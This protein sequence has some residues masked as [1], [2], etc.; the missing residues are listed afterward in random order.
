VGD[1]VRDY[2]EIAES[3]EKALEGVALPPAFAG[4]IGCMK[5][6]PELVAKIACW[7]DTLWLII[8]R[9]LNNGGS[10]TDE[11]YFLHACALLESEEA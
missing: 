10:A 6:H 7:D 8:E 3:F 9:F 5:R 11:E 2:R 4:A 1:I